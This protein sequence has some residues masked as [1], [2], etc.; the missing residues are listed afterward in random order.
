MRPAAWQCLDNR[1]KIKN[2]NCEADIERTIVKRHHCDHRVILPGN[3]RMS[4]LQNVAGEGNRN[5]GGE[6]LL[7]IPEVGDG[8]REIR[9]N[10]R[11]HR[12][13]RLK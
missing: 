8:V 9:Y 3:D 2:A 12:G 7:L 6:C 13:M 11:G 5:V 10:R 1:A 4:K